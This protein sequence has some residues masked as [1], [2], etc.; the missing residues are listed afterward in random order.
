MLAIYLLG[1]SDRIPNIGYT[2][3]EITIEKIK[4]KK[5]R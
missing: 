5:F 4:N 3:Y 2:N 1:Q